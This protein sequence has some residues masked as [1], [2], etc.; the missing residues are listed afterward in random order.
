MYSCR[1]SNWHALLRS[2]QSA[3]GWCYRRTLL[4]A[5]H[6]CCAASSSRPFVDVRNVGDGANHIWTHTSP[7]CRSRIAKPHTPHVGMWTHFFFYSV[8][9]LVSHLLLHRNNCFWFMRR[10][11]RW[12]RIVSDFFFS[13]LFMWF[14]VSSF[15]L[16]A[17]SNTLSNKI[18][19]RSS[20][21]PARC[22]CG[23]C[24]TTA[25]NVIF[26]WA[27]LIPFRARAS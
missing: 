15:I 23:I 22:V 27:N 4:R 18:F 20:P 8:L 25:G 9:R 14:C 13:V 16:V 7:Q 12:D 5:L 17:S 19:A 24:F 2:P 26:V 11:R 3:Y 21:H 10:W 6:D 1:F